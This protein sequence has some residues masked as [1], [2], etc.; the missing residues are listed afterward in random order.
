MGRTVK[1]IKCDVMYCLLHI[2][3]FATLVVLVLFLLAAN[4]WPLTESGSD[5]T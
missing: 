2:P 4:V 1:N 5:H 3:L